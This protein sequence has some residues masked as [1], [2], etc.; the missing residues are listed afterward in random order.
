MATT[1]KN[2][3]S[4]LNKD[5]LNSLKN[6]E[7]V[8]AFGDQA[9]DKAKQKSSQA[10]RESKRI[11]LEREK[12]ALVKEGHLLDIKHER[13]LFDLEQQNK[14]YNKLKKQEETGERE[15]ITLDPTPP[16]LT[17]SE[18]TAGT[19]P[20]RYKTSSRG[21]TSNQI[22]VKIY[23]KNNTLIVDYILEYPN[24]S[25]NDIKQS[26]DFIIDQLK[27]DKDQANVLKDKRY[28][29]HI[30]GVPEDQKII[31]PSPSTG[32]SD[33]EYQIALI[34]ENG[35][36]L[37]N[38]TIVEG[39]YPAAKKNL[40]E[41]K[42]ANKKALDDLKKDKKQ[43]QKDAKKKREERRKKRKA[44]LTDDEK[45]ARKARRKAV[46]QNA[47]KTIEPII[48]LIL[49]EKIAE[50]VAQNEKI[51]KLVDDTNAI[52]TDANES[53]D[54]TKLNNAKLARDN[55][56]KI[57]NDN[58]A[59]IIKIR[60]D[61]ARISVYISIFSIIVNIISAIPIPTSVPPGIGIPTSL[62]IKLVKIL[63]KANRIL[64]SLSAL[65]PI[66]L[67]VLERAINILRDYKAQLLDINGQL[68]NAASSGIGGTGGL[69]NNGVGVNGDS[70]IGGGGGI[71]V[72][73]LEETYKGFRF[74]IR[75]D[76]SFGGISVGGFK[77]H[78]AVAIDK[79]N[80][81]VLKS[82]LS[83]TLD[84]DDLVSQ[85]KLVID[86]QKLIA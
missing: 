60:D 45:K 50:V 46:F 23:D 73:I 37:P 40:L 10:I 13:K 9:L 84:P 41:R 83:F 79:N 8:K 5:T 58:E 62:I 38:G 12:I 1:N 67:G 6:S 47:K 22:E 39:N 42:D 21:K 68:E 44:K 72:G 65:I 54:P 48:T 75:E 78:Y 59:K 43:A 71:Q 7:Q 69:L 61:I 70:G 53:G 55:A 11:Q 27:K 36:T 33:E 51:G 28:L 81:D 20:Y 15:N 29:T 74:A 34:N 26:T 86:Q 77:R 2:I 76:N 19:P 63:D 56:I 24:T 31:P 52:I 32:L 18:V 82:E 4:L 35:G 3:A 57:I 25:F 17:Q 64:L 16:Q 30:Y 80:V 49:T 66:L 14:L 85:L